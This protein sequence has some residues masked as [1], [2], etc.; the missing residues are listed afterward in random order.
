MAS[1]ERFLGKKVEIPEDRRYVPKQGLWGKLDNKT[2]V[3]GLSEPALVLAGG[4]ND[5]EQLVENGDAIREGDAVA[6]A[7]T[8]KIQYFDAPIRGSIHFNPAV[9]ESPLLV[10][11]DSYASGWIFKIKPEEGTEKAMEKMAEA[12]AYINSLK[13]TEG[14]KNPDGLKGGVSGMCKAVYTGIR[15]QKV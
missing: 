14:F 5:L 12:P 3:F 11:K 8:A 2:I 9:K 10:L 6:F 7:I 15:E 4:F 13:Y 1:I